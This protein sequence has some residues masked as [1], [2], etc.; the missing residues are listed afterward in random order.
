MSSFFLK[1]IC[2]ASDF[3]YDTETTLQEAAHDGDLTTV[4]RLLSLDVDVNCQNDFGSTPLLLATM[5]GHTQIVENLIQ[6]KGNINHQG[7]LGWTPLHAACFYGHSELVSLLLE[8]GADPRK[9]T[10]LSKRPGEEFDLSVPFNMCLE[11][12]KVLKQSPVSPSGSSRSKR[13]SVRS[14]KRG[15]EKTMQKQQSFS[16]LEIQSYWQTRMSEAEN[17]GIKGSFRRLKSRLSKSKSKRS[18]LST[19]ASESKY[20]N[21]NEDADHYANELAAV[22][23]LYDQISAVEGVPQ[24]WREQSKEFERQIKESFLVWKREGKAI[25]ETFAAQLRPG[26]EDLLTFDE[27]EA[28]IQCFGAPEWFPLTLVGYDVLLKHFDPQGTGYLSL[29]LVMK[30]ISHIKGKSPGLGVEP[31][32]DQL[33]KNS[34]GCLPINHPVRKFFLNLAYHPI[35]QRTV[36]LAI[37][38]NSTVMAMVDY[39]VVDPLTGDPTPNGSLRNTIVQTSEPIFTA[40]F[41]LEMVVRVIALGFVRGPYTYL[42]NGWNGFDFMVVC[43]SIM[44]LNPKAKQLKVLKVFRVLRPLKALSRLEG[45]KLIINGL[46]ESLASLRD[47]LLIFLL[48]MYLFTT[49]ALDTFGGNMHARCRLTPF[50]VVLDRNCTNYYDSC[51]ATY[52]LNVTANPDAWRCLDVANDDPSWTL[53]SSPWNTPRD[54]IWPTNPSEFPLRLCSI[55]GGGNNICV[56]GQYCGSDYDLMGNPRFIDTSIPYGVSRLTFTTY[57]PDFGYGTYVFDNFGQAFLSLFYQILTLTNWSL[58]EFMGMDAVG[59]TTSALFFILFTFVGAYIMLNLVLGVMT[60]GLMHEEQHE[61][62]EADEEENMEGEQESPLN[63]EHEKHNE[64]EAEGVLTINVHEDEA[65]KNLKQESPPVGCWGRFVAFADSDRFGNIMLGCIIINTVILAMDHFPEDAAFTGKLTPI[66]YVLTGAFT[67][68]MCVTVAAHGIIAYIRSPVTLFDGFIVITSVVELLMDLTGRGGKGGISALRTFRLFRLF[69]LAKASKNL[70]ILLHK[71][72]VTFAQMGNFGLLLVMFNYIFALLGMQFFANKLH[73]HPVTGA[74]IKFGEP[75]YNTSMIPRQN[76]DSF[77]WAFS[78]VFGTLTMDNWDYCYQMCRVATGGVA[79]IYFLL[80][81]LI[82]GFVVMNMFMAILLMNFAKDE[83]HGEGHGHSHGEEGTENNETATPTGIRGKIKRALGLL[84]LFCRTKILNSQPGLL[85]SKMNTKLQAYLEYIRKPLKRIVEDNRFTN[86]VLGAVLI[87]SL[88]LVVDNPL[89]DPNGFVS[90]SIQKSNVF[91]GYFFAIEALMKI[92]ALH[93]FGPKTAY[94]YDSWNLIDFFVTFFGVI[95]LFNIGASSSLTSIRMIRVVRPLRMINRIEGLK[96]VVSVILK[97]IPTMI[98]ICAISILF[99]LIFSI[100]SV[101]FLKGALYHCAGSSQLNYDQYQLLVNPVTWEEMTSAQQGWFSNSSCPDANTFPLIPTSEDLCNCWF[102]DSWQELN[103]YPINFN[104]VGSAFFTL[105]ECATLSNWQGIMWNAVDSRGIGLE[106]VTNHNQLWMGFFLVFVM[107]VGLFLINVFVGALVDFFNRIK[108]E[109]KENGVFTTQAQLEWVEVRYLIKTMKEDRKF[110][111]P[112]NKFRNMCYKL[113]VSDKGQGGEVTRTAILEPISLTIIIMNG[114]VM[115]LQYYGQP[116]MY[117]MVLTQLN[118]IFT[119][120][121]NFEASIKIIAFWRSFFNDG[122]NIFDIVVVAMADLSLLYGLATGNS[123]GP[124]ASIGRVL[125]LFRLVQVSK[126]F[127]GVKHLLISLISSVPGF[128]NVAALLILVYFIYAVLG[129]QMFATTAANTVIT[130][131]TNF[132]SLGVALITLFIISTGD[133]WNS[134]VHGYA[135]HNPGCTDTVEYDPNWCELHDFRPGCVP[136]NGCGSFYALPF[137]YTFYIVLNIILMNLFVGVILDSMSTD[138]TTRE[139]LEDLTPEVVELYN[140]LWDKIDPYKTNNLP[141]YLFPQFLKMLDGPLGLS[142]EEKSIPENLSSVIQRLEISPRTVK[143]VSCFYYDD[144]ITALAKEMF[145]KKH[146]QAEV[147][148]LASA[149]AISAVSRIKRMVQERS[150][151]LKRLL[152]AKT[153]LN[154]QTQKA[155]EIPSTLD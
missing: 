13:S 117:G 133:N 22:E 97:S 49:V 121:F 21:I 86:F 98:E 154:K 123:L 12:Q 138:E 120:F 61:H 41:T 139:K 81:I 122:W 77:A 75:G 114:I 28:A 136:L 64:K 149:T 6:Y 79:I 65:D 137:F 46:I 148:A 152:S 99:L 126:A 56:Q 147:D 19:Q 51:W 76:F 84:V 31:F 135:T 130:P 38:A 66:N 87:S 72:L 145:R 55:A 124:V 44:T 109:D 62:E 93:A 91:F 94:F 141:A 63:N 33:A 59:Q 71:M 110:P 54:C 18:N 143:G 34:L 27:F 37:M 29:Q 23:S 78:T 111:I 11:I 57:F 100:F 3:L 103:P 1:F 106:P 5:A 73:F 10:A 58:M 16:P 39:S 118:L 48:V 45:L 134:F 42:R 8:N 7:P 132:R 15:Y 127:E 30:F 25:Q 36:I 50:P 102:Q 74:L 113:V 131:M 153:L 20:H 70:Q 43:T 116:D 4:T 119:L 104:N 115:A 2:G 80:L 125:R 52:L 14:D 92:I 60:E 32:P 85:V 90:T 140:Q 142:E 83:G 40:I 88:L 128:A 95:T 24:G 26:E 67:I 108:N 35:F 96:K 82:G 9:K 47:V 155:L 105:F 89:N 150:A 129:V 151:T 107:I 68:E 69:K 101:S 17:S 53:S 144:I 146:D 112:K